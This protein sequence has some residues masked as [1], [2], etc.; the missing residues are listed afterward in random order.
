MRNT[1]KLRVFEYRVVRKIT[2]NKRD[3]AGGEWRRLHKEEL[4]DLYFRVSQLHG[5]S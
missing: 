3:E 2:G 1:H 5:T 4:R